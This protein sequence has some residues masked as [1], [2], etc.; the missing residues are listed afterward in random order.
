M[1]FTTVCKAV[2]RSFGQLHSD[3]I[4]TSPGDYIFRVPVTGYYTFTGWGPGGGGG[5]CRSSNGGGG[6]AS[7]G[8][9]QYVNVYLY[10]GEEVHY[11]IGSRGTN[12]TITGVPAPGSNTTIT[13]ARLSIAMV[14]PGGLGGHSDDSSSGAGGLPGAM[15]TGGTYNAQGTAGSAGSTDGGNG[16][17]APLPLEGG[18]IGGIGA[19]GLLFGDGGDGA[20]P[21]GG[22]GGGY[23][24]PANNGGF[25]GAGG[26]KFER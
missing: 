9:S 11:T 4:F 3:L 15:P 19:H 17:A 16:A 12:G 13:F 1:T 7:G 5:A 26:V 20:A 18:G 10:A 21:G 23:D 22:G 14:I 8:V 6:G 25:G 2:P 24:G